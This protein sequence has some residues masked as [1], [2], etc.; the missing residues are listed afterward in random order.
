MSYQPNR[1]YGFIGNMRTAALVGMNGSIDWMCVPHFDSPSVFAAMLDD[2]KG[3]CFQIVPSDPLLE[4]TQLYW[5]DTNILVTR[6]FCANGFG[7]IEDFMPV[8]DPPHWI[9]SER[10][11]T[12]DDLNKTKMATSWHDQVIRRVKVTRGCVRFRLQCHP[13]FDYAR[14]THHTRMTIHGAVFHSDHLSMALAADVPL[15][16][17]TRGGQAKFVLQ[18]GQVAVFILRPLKDGQ[19]GRCL[20]R[21]QTEELFQHTVDYWQRWLSKCTYTGRWR[22]MMK[23][24]RS[25]TKLMTFVP[26]G[27]IV[28]APT[29]SLP[30]SLG[31]G[32]QPGRPIYKAQLRDARLLFEYMLGYANHLGLYAEETGDHGEAL[33]NFPQAFTHIALISAA[34]NL[35]RTLSGCA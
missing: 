15:I 27:A 30:E 14:A 22:E 9:Q 11:T 3:G 20:T 18:A 34:Y 21:Q 10:D 17:D 31:S 7:E 23:V 25:R 28:A 32:T 2:E 24:L 4:T 35:D 5:P 33:G 13:T 19:G 8:G 6:F 26:R 29:C 1:N 12:V 16:R